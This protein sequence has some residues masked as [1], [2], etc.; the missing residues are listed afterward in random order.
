[1]KIFIETERLILRELLLTDVEGMFLLDSDPE[2]HRYLGNE[3]V[4]SKEEIEEIIRFIRRQYVDNGIGRWAVIEKRTEDFIGW[5]GL[6][7]VTEPINNRVNFYDLG[8]RLR[9]EY[10]G[11]GIATEASKALV[12]YAFDTLKTDSI[13]AIVECGNEASEKVLLKT[14]FRLIEKCLLDGVE[15]HW[16]QLKKFSDDEQMKIL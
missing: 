2:V 12:S 11:K 7:L 1:M 10:W 5:A 6:K 16:F 15:H 8:Y 4:T 14:G 9:K 3:P 13:H